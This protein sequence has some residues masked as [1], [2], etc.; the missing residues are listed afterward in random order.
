MVFGEVLL[1]PCI[2]RFLSS[3][4]S[5]TPQLLNACV[6][7]SVNLSQDSASWPRLGALSLACDLPH[8]SCIAP[9]LTLYGMSQEEPG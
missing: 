9:Y 4:S 2:A 1:G 3:N 7:N 5:E 6:Y 8:F